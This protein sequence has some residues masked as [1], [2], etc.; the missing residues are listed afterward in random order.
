MLG[1]KN[2]ITPEEQKFL[3][4]IKNGDEKFVAE[5]LQSG[6]NIN[7]TFRTKEETEANPLVLAAKEGH[8]NIVRLLIANG[9]DAC[10]DVTAYVMALKNNHKEIADEILHSEAMGKIQP[11]DFNALVDTENLSALMKLAEVKENNDLLRTFSQ[12]N[13]L[14]AKKKIS[15][16]FAEVLE[17]ASSKLKYPLVKE[18][19]ME[20]F[21]ASFLMHKVAQRKNYSFLSF[22][23]LA[24]QERYR[25]HPEDTQAWRVLG[26]YKLK[27]QDFLNRNIKER[28]E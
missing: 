24:Y 17:Y 15:E 21:D 6:G 26:E 1:E 14:D 5:Y 16:E 28:E 12:E 27:I 20:G 23:F 10:Y 13:I 7:F 11:K 19:I 2:K 3:I 4:H 25:R 22:L 9:I 8:L 18:M